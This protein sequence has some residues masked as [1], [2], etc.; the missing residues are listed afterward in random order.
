MVEGFAPRC[1][2]LEEY[3]EV[4]EAEEL[5]FNKKSATETAFCEIKWCWGL[6]DI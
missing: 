4:S 5:V 6:F 1:F 2:V 3:K